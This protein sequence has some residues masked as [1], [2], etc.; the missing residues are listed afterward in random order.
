MPATQSMVQG[1]SAWQVRFVRLYDGIPVAQ[2]SL[3]VSVDPQGQ[4]VNY[5]RNWHDLAPTGGAVPLLGQAAAEQALAVL[6]V[7][8]AY[9]LEM[10]PSSLQGGTPE[11]QAPELV[12][13]FRDAR[14]ELGQV[15]FD[16]VSGQV[17][18]ADGLAFDAPS[19]PP[20][21]LLGSW[22]ETP[23][24][25]FSQAGLLP[26]GVGPNDPVTLGPA[27][28]ALLQTLQTPSFGG[29]SM[30]APTPPGPYGM[31]IARA[32]AAGIL[33]PGAADQAS[34]TVSREELA[35]WT[36]QAL[37]YGALLGMPNR[38]DVKFTDASLIA[39]AYVNAVGIAQGLAIVTGDA[40]HRFQPLQPVTWAQFATIL[41]RAAT[42]TAANP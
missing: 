39:P 26:A 12:Y 24:W 34:Q 16:A 19:G 20:A 6:P 29:S 36:V 7:Q 42:H 9:E 40:E 41:M 3:V 10:T 14:N 25:A 22:A 37:G 33:A 38:V 5:Y 30:S 15:Q 35:D 31:D 23:L 2:D 21:A 32:I 4:V 13:A 27:I 28:H 11:P 8:L 1:G 17:Y 18:G